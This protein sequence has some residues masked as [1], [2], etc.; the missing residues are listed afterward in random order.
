[1]A[2]LIKKPESMAKHKTSHLPAP[3]IQLSANSVSPSFN[4]IESTGTIEKPESMANHKTSPFPSSTKQHFIQ[5]ADIDVS[6][7]FNII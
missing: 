2:G 7:E 4:L 1:M 3:L 5:L 6:L